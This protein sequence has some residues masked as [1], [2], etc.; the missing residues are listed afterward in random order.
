MRY[1]APK[2][3]YRCI[4]CLWKLG[5]GYDRVA[6][7]LRCRKRTVYRISKR[8]PQDLLR[9][10]YAAKH[11]SLKLLKPIIDRVRLAEERAH[12]ALLNLPNKKRKLYLRTTIWKWF[13]HGLNP[14][15]APRL[16]G[17][18]RVHFRQHIA[19][20]FQPGMSMDNYAEVWQ[21]DHIM[22][23]AKFDLRRDDHRK[24]C[25]HFTNYQ[26]LFCRTNKKKSARVTP[27]QPE[28]IFNH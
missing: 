6:R 25:F 17:C 23:C 19:S 10:K 27:H 4:P 21:L 22:P 28:L 7:L 1:N 13:K 14:K 24:M 12:K 9:P 2:P 8:Q 26:P 18:S 3:H 5:L 15:A 16:V 11:R 20:Q